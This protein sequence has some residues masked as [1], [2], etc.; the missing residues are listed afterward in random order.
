[1][2]LSTVYGLLPRN[3]GAKVVKNWGKK[4]NLKEVPALYIN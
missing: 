2:D 1:M 3:V 4:R